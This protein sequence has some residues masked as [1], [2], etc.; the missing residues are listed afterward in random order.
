MRRRSP[1]SPPNQPTRVTAL[2]DPVAFDELWSLRPFLVAVVRRL[3]RDQT[4]VEDVVQETL[5]RAFAHRDEIERDGL[6]CYLVTIARRV[7]IDELRRRSRQAVPIGVIS[8][9]RGPTG[10][11]PADICA[12]RAVVAQVMGRIGRLSPQERAVLAQRVRQAPGPM[13][14]ATR[15]TLRRA[16]VKLGAALDL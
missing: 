13:G 5:L 4:T 8:E 7:S 14:T 9:H 6:R 1:A 12:R 15:A 16:R 11:D 10:E 2:E 3:V